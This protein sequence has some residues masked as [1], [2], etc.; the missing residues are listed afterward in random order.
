[1]HQPEGPFWLEPD[2]DPARFPDPQYALREPDGLLAVGGDLSPARLLNA[3]RQG[4]FPWYSDGQPI[5]W[6]SPDPRMVLYPDHLKISRSLRKTLRKR[7]FD[8]T[9][10]CAF[11]EVVSACS[12]PRPG[13]DGTWITQEMAQ[14]YRQLHRL[15]FA[16]SVECWEGDELVGGLYGVNMGKVFFGES[17]F[18]R[19]SDASKTALAYLSRQLRRWDFG[20]IDCQVYTVHLASLG[21]EEIARPRFLEQLDRWCEPFDAHQG[22]W[23][24]QSDIAEQW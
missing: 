7:R 10:D 23:Q 11:A 6:W 1:M 3:Y 24:L 21:A 8:V 22:A 5:L 19:R 14:A 20:L 2:S 18:S 4:I 13:Q 15:G 12:E 16:H 9:L 17:M